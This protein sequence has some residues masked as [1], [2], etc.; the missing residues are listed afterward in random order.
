LEGA[1]EIGA[2]AVRP[3][4]FRL[5]VAITNTAPWQGQNRERTLRQTFVSTHTILTVR[6]GEF[7]SLMDPP[8]NLKPFAEACQNVKTWPVLAGEEG[9]RQTLLSSPIILYDYPR[10]APESPG[11]LFDAGEID[12]LLTLNILTLTDE[13]K[14]EMCATDPRA[15]RILER[16]EAFTAEDFMGLHG[17]MRELRMLR[18]EGPV[19]PLFNDVERAVPG[20][21]MV[22]GVAV[23]K[24]S[25]VLLRPRPGRDIMDVVLAG[26]VAVVEAI[27]Q[28]YDERVHVGV[29]VQ[30]DP[31]RD[32]GEARMIGHRF[33]FS[34]EE[35]EPL[36]EEAESP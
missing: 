24:G 17:T 33:F 16:T 15:R 27:E 36:V 7:V 32:L 18:E 3:G 8:P 2:E 35:I 1:V 29:T 22:G 19:D 21:L 9:Q 10:I 6:D 31:G 13:E 12:Q 14:A 23:A 26:K 30:E 25:R 11:D 4:L 5:T 20:T 34:P 28:D